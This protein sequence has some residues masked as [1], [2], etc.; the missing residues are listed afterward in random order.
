L[1]ALSPSRIGQRPD[2]T[3]SFADH[4]PIAAL[5]GLGFQPIDSMVVERIRY[6]TR[7]RAGPLGQAAQQ[8]E[9]TQ[10]S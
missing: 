7:R 5:L 1:W 8:G 4:V 3:L 6:A 10:S 2:D 9:F